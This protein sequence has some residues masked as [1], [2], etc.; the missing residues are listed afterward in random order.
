MSLAEF[1]IMTV[2][3]INAGPLQSRA[4]SQEF[5]RDARAVAMAASEESSKIFS[6]TFALIFLLRMWKVPN[7]ATSH[8]H[9]TLMYGRTQ[10]GIPSY[11]RVLL[12]YTIP[13]IYGNSIPCASHAALS[14]GCSVPNGPSS[15]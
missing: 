14:A 2:T 11:A 3:E 5:R 15:T 9:Y 1:N 4:F 13:G 10:Y 8:M 7:L 6:M 12:S